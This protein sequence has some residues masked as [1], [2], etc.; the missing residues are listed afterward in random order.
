MRLAEN[1]IAVIRAIV[2]RIVGCDVRIWLYGSRLDDQSKGGDLDL[3]LESQRK[4]SLLQRAEIKLTL[5]QE[6][7]IPVDVLVYQSS[8]APTAF[9]SIALSRAVLIA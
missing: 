3:L 6:L 4:I 5:E 8:E 1:Q 7:Q 9:Q 2:H